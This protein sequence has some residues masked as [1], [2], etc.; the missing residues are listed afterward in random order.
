MKTNYLYYLGLIAVSIIWGANFGIS[1]WGMD[2]FSAEI[3]VFFRFGL[4]IPVLFLLLYKLEGN[5]MVEKKDFLKLAVIGIFGVT[6]LEIAVMYS[7]KFTTLANASLLNVA[8]WPIFAALFAP[9]F[10]KE[11]LTRK[12]VAGGAIALV[13]VTLIILGGGEG[14][15]LSSQYMLGNMLALSISLIGALFNLACMPMMKKYSP[16]KVTTWYILFGTILLFPFTFGGWSDV[17]WSNLTMPVY[18]AIVYNVILCTIVAF[19]L[20]NLAMSKVGATKSNFFRYVVP[21][22]AAVTG[23]LFFGEPIMLAQILGAAIIMSGLMI[24]G[25]ERKAARPN[26][27]KDQDPDPLGKSKIAT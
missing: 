18:G 23:A 6:I 4:A 25:S 13:G 27:D 2:F 12:V 21:A 1:R 5:I 10:T 14:I 24:I 19:V 17:N 15:D 26:T 8:P 22:A 9:L 11:L 3:F 20:W 16:L 7:I